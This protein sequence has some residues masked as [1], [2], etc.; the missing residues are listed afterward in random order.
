MR[1]LILQRIAGSV[2]R[3]GMRLR[4]RR[5]LSLD[6]NYGDGDVDMVS[7]VLSEPPV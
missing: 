3:M 2:T 4:R 5:S 6:G 1:S 7:D